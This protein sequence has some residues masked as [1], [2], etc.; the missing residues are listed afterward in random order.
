MLH[1]YIYVCTYIS[2][3]IRNLIAIQTDS[4]SMYN[5]MN[6]VDTEVVCLLNNIQSMDIHLWLTTTPLITCV[7]IPYERNWLRRCRNKWISH[8]FWMLLASKWT[9]WVKIENKFVF[10]CWFNLIGLPNATCATQRQKNVIQYVCIDLVWEAQ[11][12]GKWLAIHTAWSDILWNAESQEIRLSASICFV[13]FD[14]TEVNSSIEFYAT[15]PKTQQQELRR[16]VRR[17]QSV[18]QIILI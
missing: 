8:R 2:I 13:K 14:N 16:Y 3:D 9:L 6:S 12:D 17:R 15:T 5:S 7:T 4:V 11:A 10:I 1:H 18:T